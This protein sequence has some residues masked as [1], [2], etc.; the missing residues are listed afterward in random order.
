MKIRR[1]WTNAR[2]AR[3][4]RVR[5]GSF[6]RLLPS[7]SAEQRWQRLTQRS[8]NGHHRRRSDAS[9]RRLRRRRTAGKR[10]SA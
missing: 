1:C 7:G 10:R 9:C 4:C 5:E 6:P 8:R 3:G 2:N